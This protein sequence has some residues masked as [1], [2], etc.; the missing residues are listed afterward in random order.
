MWNLPLFSFSLEL[1]S[2]KQSFKDRLLADQINTFVLFCLNWPVAF[3]KAALNN[4]VHFSGKLSVWNLSLH[5]LRDVRC[6]TN[7]KYLQPAR[8]FTFRK[9]IHTHYVNK[10]LWNGKHF[11]C[12]HKQKLTASIGSNM[13][14]LWW[15]RKYISFS[16]SLF[17]Y[18]S[19]S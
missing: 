11:F 7:S 15:T 18:K 17:D 12:W 8:I 5:K 6:Y 4:I 3:K 1:F 13:I 16:L 10:L 14:L 19:S 2:S 9:N